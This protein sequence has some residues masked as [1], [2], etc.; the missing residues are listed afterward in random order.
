[1]NKIIVKAELSMSEVLYDEFLENI[2]ENGF[3]LVQYH[4]GVIRIEKPDGE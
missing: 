3:V 4:D 1:M 2:E